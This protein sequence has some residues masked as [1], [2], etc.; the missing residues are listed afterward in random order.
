MTL[1]DNIIRLPDVL[2]SMIFYY[3]SLD[4]FL[5]DE[6]KL[7]KNVIGVYNIDRSIGL[8]NNPGSYYIKNVMDFQ[9]YVFW[10]LSSYE[11]QKK[12]GFIRFGAYYG[13]WEYDRIVLNP[14]IKIKIEVQSITN[15][16]EPDSDNENNTEEEDEDEDEK[17]F[18]IFKEN[19]R[20]L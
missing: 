4:I 10:S 20:L 14:F 16:L 1:T 7:I 5:S 9:E 11:D 12:D 19:I 3:I 13:A 15:K 6:T 17:N 8:F 2:K 18:N